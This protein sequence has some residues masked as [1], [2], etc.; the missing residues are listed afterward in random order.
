MSEDLSWFD[1]HFPSDRGEFLASSLAKY[2]ACDRRQSGMCGEV[3]RLD[4][5]SNH[6]PRFV[7][8]KVPNGSPDPAESKRR[9][10]KEMWIQASMYYHPCVHWPFELAEVLDTPVALYRYWD[11]D[12]SDWVGDH[13]ISEIAR[14]SVLAY[15]ATGLRHCHRRGMR[16]HQDLK[17][18][19]VFLRDLRNDFAVD[20]DIDVY[21]RPLVA[22]FGLSN[23]A[24]DL[25][26]FD[27]SKPYMAPEQWNKEELSPATDAFAFGVISFELLSGGLHPIGETTSEWW[28]APAEGNS[29]KWTRADF[30]RKWVAKGVPVV[31]RKVGPEPARQ[32]ILAAL[33]PTP[34]NRPSMDELIDAMCDAVDALSDKAAYYVRFYIDHVDSQAQPS[35]EHGGWPHLERRLRWLEEEFG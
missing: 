17:P 31:E 25:G 29:K 11:G 10:V 18:A 20:S 32:A 16:A 8:A 6:Y 19:N 23:A 15:L 12:L 30:W 13:S 27:G 1:S 28:P 4:Q 33:S 35:V 14:L 24:K 9:F 3:Y 34:S 7:C 22:D 26:V 5:G 21:T 2:G